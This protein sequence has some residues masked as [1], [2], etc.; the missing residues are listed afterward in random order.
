MKLSFKYQVPAWR[1]FLGVVFCSAGAIGMGYL[2]YINQKGLRIFQLITFSPEASSLIYLASS[3]VLLLCVALF[4]VLIV[5]S[6][7]GPVVLT[8]EETYVVVPRASLKGELLSIPYSSIKQLLVQDLQRQQ[9][10]TINSSVGQARVL[11]V[12]FRNVGEFSSFKLA[13]ASRING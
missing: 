3:L 6:L 10:I 13:L 4:V 9:M 7:N 8:I 12:G 1:N 2:S 5:R 11:S